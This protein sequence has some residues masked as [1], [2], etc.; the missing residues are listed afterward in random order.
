MQ[1]DEYGKQHRLQVPKN[2][3]P[4]SSQQLVQGSTVLAALVPHIQVPSAMLTAQW[5]AGAPKKP[6]LWE[7]LTWVTSTLKS[8]LCDPMG[9]EHSFLF[10]HTALI[11]QGKS[12]MFECC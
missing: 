11:R 2:T 4:L 7:N 3:S 1:K 6:W 5:D 12:V 10:L 8:Y 9:E